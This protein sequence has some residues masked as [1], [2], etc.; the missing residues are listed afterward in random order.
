MAFGYTRETSVLEARIG[1]IFGMGDWF[2]ILKETFMSEAGGV[3]G[4]CSQAFKEAF[5]RGD[6]GGQLCTTCT[7]ASTWCKCT[8]SPLST[9]MWIGPS[10]GLQARRHRRAAAHYMYMR[11][12]LVQVHEWPNVYMYVD[13]TVTVPFKMINST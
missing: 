9:G 1:F 5:K 11:E 12:Y 7:C 3:A 4:E 2:C 10:Q 13:W 8:S 6:V